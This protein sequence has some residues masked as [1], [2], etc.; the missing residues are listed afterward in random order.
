MVEIEMLWLRY[1]TILGNSIGK[2][3]ENWERKKERAGEGGE[4]ER[5]RK[6]ENK[7]KEEKERKKEKEEKGIGKH[8]ILKYVFDS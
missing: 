4:K 7:G 8:L 2:G 3:L 6:K 5:K 1:Y